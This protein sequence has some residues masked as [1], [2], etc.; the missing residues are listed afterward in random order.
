[1]AVV[2]KRNVTLAEVAEDPRLFACY[3]YEELFAI[4][5]KDLRDIYE[6][7]VPRAFEHMRGR[8]KALDALATQLDIDRISTI[9]DIVPVLFPHT[10]SKSYP[11]AFIEKGQFG[12][13]NQWLDKLTAHDLTQLDV[14]ACDSLDSWIGMIESRTPAR[15]YCSSGTTGKMSFNNTSLD[16]EPWSVAGFCQTR[17]PFRDEPGVDLRAHP[18]MPLVAPYVRNGATGVAHRFKRLVNQLYGGD[19]KMVIALNG[20]VNADMLWLAGKL[21]GA[22]AR[23]ELGQL[24][25]TPALERWVP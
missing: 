14:S 24:E 17:E 10:M 19:E 1:M 11:L 5:Q 23:G 7:A 13:M 4:K 8:I 22:E 16:E 2:Q 15:I 25:L 9:D 12:R 6:H 20:T 21:R 3:S 18:E